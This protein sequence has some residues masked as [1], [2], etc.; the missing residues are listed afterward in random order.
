ME[1]V[2][3]SI[4]EVSEMLQVPPSSLRYWE[5]E[6][7]Q[8]TPKRNDRGTRFY[9]K[10][11]IE[12]IKQI[13]YLRDENKLTIKGIQRRLNSDKPGVDKHQQIAERLRK[14]RQELV[15]IRKAL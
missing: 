14:I 5:S 13:I 6:I 2:Y 7:R 12:T 3:Y 9:T 8:L 1:K 11:N 15:E 4:A 10:D